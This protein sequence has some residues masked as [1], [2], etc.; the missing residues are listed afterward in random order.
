M[1]LDQY[2]FTI[3]PNLPEPGSNSGEEISYWRKDWQLQEFIGSGNCEEV[4]VTEDL[5]NSI[6]SSLDAIYQDADIYER[7]SELKTHTRNA[8]TAALILIKSG[9]GVIYDAN[10]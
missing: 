8:F 6:L 3:H 9:K 1:G 4:I 2:L 5:C 7:D 10:W